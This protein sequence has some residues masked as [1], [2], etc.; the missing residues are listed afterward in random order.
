M[1]DSIAFLSVVE[2]LA[3]YRRGELSP[4]EAVRV[5]YERLERIEPVINAFCHVADREESLRLARESEARWR[6]GNPR[7]EM[8]GVPIT[9]KDAILAKGWP[10][11]KGSKTVEPKQPWLEDAPAV[12]R[13][14]EQGAIILGKTTTPEFGWKGVTDSPLSG[15]T[16]NPWNPHTT[17]GGSSGGAAAALAAGI[18]HAAI[19]TD[20]G[21]S[22]RIPAAFCGLVAI[23]ATSGRVPNYPPSAAGTLGHIGPMTHTVADA[24]HLLNLIAIPDARD[25][26][27]LPPADIDYRI[28]LNGGVRGLRLA[29]S[30]ALGFAKVEPA[31]A[32]LAAKAARAFE[33]LGARVEEVAAPFED[34]TGI[35]R[36]HFFAG[37]AHSVRHHTP[38]QLAMLDP[39]LMKIIEHARKV[40]ITEYMS[41][42]DQRA[43][44]GRSTRSF[45][46]T[47][48]LLLT[49]TLAVAAFTAG[50]LAPDGYGDDWVNWTPFT[51]AF[52]LTGQ[53]AISVP[54]G[55]TREG[56]PVG[57]QIVGAMHQDALV[58]RAAQA[59][60][61][62]H[63]AGRHPSL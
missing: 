15:I 7:G 9:V 24:A 20:A 31:V 60:Q 59:Y 52:N 12:A 19:G 17:P 41:A 25:W 21:G 44:L 13:L 53:P 35:F 16:R 22:V 56:L 33:D 43:A 5:A 62:A 10:T 30:P 4:L 39:G 36:T 23:K 3:R 63:P 54:C 29:Y 8:D 11:L 42:V 1:S 61:C 2:L 37:M 40:T 50:R 51:Y 46:Q 32:E 26:L 55:F 6:R 38:E 34:P 14:R 18:G 45:H 28:G 47:Y 27:C 48:D 57:L 58:L 49:P